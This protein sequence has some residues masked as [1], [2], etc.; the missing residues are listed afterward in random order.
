ML[1]IFHASE[2]F[3]LFRNDIFNILAVIIV[4]MEFY[5]E[6]CLKHIK[7]KNKYKNTY[8]EINKCKCKHIILSHKNIDIND[9]EEAFYLYNIEDHQKF[10]YFLK[11]CDFILVLMII[12]F[13]RM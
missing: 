5:C 11:K 12:N 3:L 4:Q 13:V 7:S 10:D 2:Y 1:V 9:V 8:Q 6:V